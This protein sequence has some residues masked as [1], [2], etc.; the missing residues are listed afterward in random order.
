MKKN[1]KKALNSI[2]IR[3]AAGLLVSFGFIFFLAS[4]LFATS[5]FTLIALLTLAAGAI[6][7]V[8]G[9]LKNNLK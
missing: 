7:G 2:T 1:Q 5:L 4:T 3:A 6:V 8:V 9:F